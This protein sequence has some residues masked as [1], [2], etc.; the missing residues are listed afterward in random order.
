MENW[1][2]VYS[3]IGSRYNLAYL[4]LGNGT[5]TQGV[6]DEVART[7]QAKGVVVERKPYLLG[8]VIATNVQLRVSAPLVRTLGEFMPTSVGML[9]LA[10]VTPLVVNTTANPTTPEGTQT[11]PAPSTTDS[12]GKLCWILGGANGKFWDIPIPG[13]PQ[14]EGSDFA[15]AGGVLERAGQVVGNTA[16]NIV[17]P[18]LVP[19]VLL[20]GLV[21]AGLYFYSKGGGRISML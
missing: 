9:Q 7:L 18:L 13:C 5:I 6:L 3:S 11:L 20:G 12:A 1:Q 19:G 4:M 17:K 14:T 8:R 15:E 2:T 16:S 21:V 10:N